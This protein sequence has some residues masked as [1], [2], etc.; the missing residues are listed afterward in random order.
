M[1][2]RDEGDDDRVRTNSTLTIHNSPKQA[3][4]TTNTTSETHCDLYKCIDTLVPRQQGTILCVTKLK[5]NRFEV[6]GKLVNGPYVF[7]RY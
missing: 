1:D 6:M 3:D 2:T 5:P 4:T 7:S